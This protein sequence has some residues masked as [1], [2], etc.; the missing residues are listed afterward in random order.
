MT[1]IDKP[2]IY[3]DIPPETYHAGIFPNSVSYSTLKLL[4]DE[5]G[6]AKYRHALDG[7]RTEKRVF[8]LG[9]A[10]HAELFG[11][12]KER[13]T[14]ITMDAA[15]AYVTDEK[16]R[17]KVDPPTW[18]TDA[19]KAARDAAYAQGLTPLLVKDREAI[20]RVATALPGHILEWFTGGT[21]EVAFLWDH[22]TGTPV[23]G[24]IDY[25]RDDAIVD[26]KTVRAT[27]TRTLQRQIWDLR[28][29]LQA[30]TYQAAYAALT[31]NAL[32][33]YIVAVDLTAPHLS[34]VVEITD[35]Y[36]DVGRSDLERAITTHRQC[37]ESGQWPAYPP[38][39]SPIDPPPWVTD[40]AA[41]REANPTIEAL[42]NLLGA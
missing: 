4:L 23:R 16:K 34:R 17:L 24:Q 10:L 6:P 21:A 19:A 40:R 31:G 9:T 42:E 28:Y 7:P 20:D 18:A 26:L 30:A 12:G 41:K 2:G 8:D 39:P 5:A 14:T 33:Y 35:E 1:T 36:L 38:A 25:L 13:L 29:Y 37:A 32:P 15:N 3:P 22:P 11:K 27:D